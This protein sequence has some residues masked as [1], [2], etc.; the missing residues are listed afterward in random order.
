MRPA[1]RAQIQLGGL[2]WAFMF[3]VGMIIL[4]AILENLVL[5]QAVD[6]LI[7]YAGNQSFSS[8]ESTEG[9]RVLEQWRNLFTAIVAFLAGMFFIGYAFLQTRGRF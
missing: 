8:T 4:G 2:G 1:D 7:D 5:E 3:F 6:P 9:L